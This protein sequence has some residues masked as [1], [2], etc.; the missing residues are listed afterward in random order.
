MCTGDIVYLPI[1]GGY[2][3]YVV[4]GVFDDNELLVISYKTKQKNWLYNSDVLTSEEFS[5]RYDNEEIYE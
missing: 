3:K 4:K 2:V 1:Q 5:K